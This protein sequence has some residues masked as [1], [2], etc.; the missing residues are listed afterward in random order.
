[1][2]P[3]LNK[4]VEKAMAEPAYLQRLMASPV[5][6]AREMGVELTEEE[7]AQMKPLNVSDANGLLDAQKAAGC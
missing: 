2:R 4:L 6:A 5:E 3:E 7:L 1:M